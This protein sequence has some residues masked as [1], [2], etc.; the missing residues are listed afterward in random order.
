M[1]GLR[2]ILLSPEGVHGWHW[3][4]QS[5]IPNTTPVLPGLPVMEA[6]QILEAKPSPT[7]QTSTWLA[8]KDA[9][10]SLYLGLRSILLSPEGVY[11]WHWVRG[12]RVC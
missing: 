3:V 2:S 6:K 12:L 7:A 9:V 10:M 8:V 5:L 11:G 4:R 1:I